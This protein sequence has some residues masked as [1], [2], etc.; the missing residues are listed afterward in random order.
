M[1]ATEHKFNSAKV[2]SPPVGTQAGS[3]LG[4]VAEETRFKIQKAEIATPAA[5]NDNRSEI[6]IVGAGDE[7]IRQ[8][9]TK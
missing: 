1:K 2:W 9:W 8:T 3:R 4:R 6:Y 7:G 5:R